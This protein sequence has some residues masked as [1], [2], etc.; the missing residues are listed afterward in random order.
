MSLAAGL[1]CQ[2]ASS[3]S[4]TEKQCGFELGCSNLIS[5]KI[6]SGG[7]S[8]CCKLFSYFIEWKFDLN[9]VAGEK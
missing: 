1:S 8:E 5:L 2:T 6:P 9:H 4:S 3:G 7:C